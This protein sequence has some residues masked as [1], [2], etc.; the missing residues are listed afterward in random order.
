MNVFRTMPRTGLP[1]EFDS[2]A[3]YQRHVQVLVDAGLIEDGSKVWWDIRPSIRYPTLELR[4]TDICTRWQD[5]VTIAA[6]YQSLLHM[7]FRLRRTTRSGALRQHARRREH[8]AGP[9][10]RGAGSN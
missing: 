7:L 9:A 8:L 5:A 1:E 2:W 10:V 3:E 4:V 6:L